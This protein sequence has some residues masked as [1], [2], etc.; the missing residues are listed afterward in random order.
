MIEKSTNLIKDIIQNRNRIVGE[1]AKKIGRQ[2]PLVRK[3]LNDLLLINTTKIP[4]MD[5]LVFVKPSKVIDRSA[6][7][8][9]EKQ[10]E[11]RAR[12]FY[13]AKKVEMMN[14]VS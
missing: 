5:E 2:S 9:V 10:K 6:K 4:K 13:Y 12:R 1:L 7:S 8:R 11:M 3:K 14:N